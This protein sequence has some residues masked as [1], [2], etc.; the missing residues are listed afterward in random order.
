VKCGRLG[1]GSIL[2]VVQSATHLLAMT[3]ASAAASTT[4]PAPPAARKTK[5]PELSPEQ[6]AKYAER[7]V[8]KAFDGSTIADNSS[9]YPKFKWSEM[10]LGKVL[11]KGGFGTVYEVRAFAA[12]NGGS[13]APRS[14]RSHRRLQMDEEVGVG[15]EESRQFIAEHCLRNG[16]DARYAVKQLSPEVVRD[17]NMCLQGIHDM[18]VEAR[19]LSNIVHPNIIKMRALASTSPYDAA[20]F[21]IMDRLYDTLEKRMLSWEARNG[22]FKGLAGR[23]MDRKGAKVGALYEERIVAAF[24]LSAAVE[25]LHE[26]NIM[27]RDLKPE[28]I[29]FDIVRHGACTVVEN[30]MEIHR[31]PHHRSFR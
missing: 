26:R 13:F 21:I 15:E 2:P 31:L 22:R 23:M 17:A 12:E 27:Y 3:T 14:S 24:D 19:F 29:G 16:G 18:A 20:F 8:N 7:A 5:A 25:H 9:E 1:K 6:L 10:K 28:N 11:G 4:A 30:A